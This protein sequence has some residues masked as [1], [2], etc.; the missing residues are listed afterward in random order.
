MYKENISKK[1]YI[2]LYKRSIYK[3]KSIKKFILNKDLKFI[4]VF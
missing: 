3:I 2:Y 4:I 1:Y